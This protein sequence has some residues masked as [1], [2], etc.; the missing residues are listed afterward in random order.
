MKILIVS[1]VVFILNVP[2]GYWRVNVKKYSWQWVFAI[3]IPVPIIIALRVYAEIGFQW[4]T[5]LFLV[6]A[7]FLGQKVGAISHVWYLKKYRRVS[8]CLIMDVSR[9]FI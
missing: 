1:L 7:F 2:F 3:H 4:Q 5:Y 8:S 9:V 6:S